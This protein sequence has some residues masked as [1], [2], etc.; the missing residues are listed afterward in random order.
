V[1]V[2]HQNRPGTSRRIKTPFE[3]LEYQKN[4]LPP[5]PSERV[6]SSLSKENHD[7]ALKEYNDVFTSRNKV[8]RTPQRATHDFSM[9]NNLKNI[10]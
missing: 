2:E 5:P 7:E 10:Y 8:I 9:I 4:I 1:K 6:L 3:D